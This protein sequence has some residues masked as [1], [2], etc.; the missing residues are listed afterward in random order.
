MYY[1]Y[2]QQHI[3]MNE[4]SNLQNTF[5]KI[6]NY[7]H[8]H[9]FK[10]IEKTTNENSTNELLLN[11]LVQR[12]NI[13]R[14]RFNISFFKQMKTFFL[15]NVTMRF[16][17]K[18]QLA[19]KSLETVNK[20]QHEQL[21][22]DLRKIIYPLNIDFEIQMPNIMLTKEITIDAA[23]DEQFFIDQTHNFLHA[24]ELIRI[25]LDEFFYAIFPQGRQKDE[26]DI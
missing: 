23:N 3:L 10:I 17:P 14:Y 1:I 26:E 5:N 8:S 18:D 6:H 12:G 4:F 9:N 15:F 13:E 7:L 20:A 16:M 22:M 11:L 19:L 25:R 24:I 21:F 2:T